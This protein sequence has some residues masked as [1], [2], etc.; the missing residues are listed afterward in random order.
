M[1]WSMSRKSVKSENLPEGPLSQ[2]KW[3]RVLRTTCSHLLCFAQL[4]AEMPEN[5]ARAPG[6]T[7]KTRNLEILIPGRVELVALTF[8]KQK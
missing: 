8:D 3:R 1:K 7:P 5:D 6:E 2:E 4:R